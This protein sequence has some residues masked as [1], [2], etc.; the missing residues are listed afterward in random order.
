MNNPLFFDPD[1]CRNETE[2]ESKFV[3]QYLLPALGYN[4]YNWSQEVAL[5]SIRLDFLVFARQILPFRINSDSP[6]ALIIEAKSPRDNLNSHV[7]KTIKYIRALNVAYGVLTNGKEFRILGEQDK[8]I[9]TIFQCKG[10]DVPDRLDKI[11]Q[12]IG[13]QEI[14]Q[15]KK[16]TI[17]SGASNDP[18]RVYNT[19]NDKPV[20]EN[21][22]SVVIPVSSSQ[23]EVIK[24]KQMKTIAVYHNKGGVGKTT[25]VVNLG[26]ALARM[27]YRVLLID[28]DSQANTTFA[29]GLMRFI[30][31]EN[32]DI[33]DK[34]IYH[35][36]SEKMQYFIPDVIRSASYSIFAVDVLPSHI[37]LVMQ[38]RI[39]QD[40]SPAK[41]RLLEKLKKVSDRYDFVFIDCPPS[42]NLYAQIGLVS[43][44]Y[45]II[46]SDLKPFANQGLNNVFRFVNE[47]N[48]FREVIGKNQLEILGILPSKIMTNDKYVKNTLPLL[49]EKIKTKYQI[50]IFDTFIFERID[51][52]KCVDNTL[53]EENAILPDPKSIYDF[54]PDCPSAHEF[55]QLCNE[56]LLKVNK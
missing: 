22:S 4:P 37:N 23:P 12:L 45:L 10:R 28:L 17:G 1:R 27:N 26:A 50:P 21:P 30:F 52:A 16:I 43:A 32:D 42:L 39:L 18:D 25:T 6:L 54:K 48:E 46:P 5:G 2:V 9:Q 24:E 36:I 3:V 7:K 20:K 38:E 40:I 53:V 47:I 56:F 35:V 41:T 15:R 29:T 8:E 34:N 44:D 49:V 14:A 19:E 33:K 55:N 11:K 31:E 51:L 13:Y